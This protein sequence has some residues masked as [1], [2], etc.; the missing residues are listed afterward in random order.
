LPLHE[1]SG[2]FYRRADKPVEHD[3][4]AEERLRF[5]KQPLVYAERALEVVN[6]GEHFGVGHP[7]TRNEEP[8]VAEVIRGQAPIA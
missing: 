1:N 2:F 6:T 5:M 4:P 8:D 7:F 3:R